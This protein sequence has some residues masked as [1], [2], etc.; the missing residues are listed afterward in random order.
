MNKIE[1]MM[2]DMLVGANTGSSFLDSMASVY[3]IVRMPGETDMQLRTRM[4]SILYTPRPDPYI[5]RL[6][7][8]L[9]RLGLTSPKQYLPIGIG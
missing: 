8:L 4:T 6:F 3:S 2:S 9:Y 5:M 1:E 7:L